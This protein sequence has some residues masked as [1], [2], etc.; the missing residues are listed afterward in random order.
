M[1][2][3]RKIFSLF[4]ILALP[5]FLLSIT[6]P[7]LNTIKENIQGNLFT[8]LGRQWDKQNVKRIHCAL[9]QNDDWSCGL[10]AF[11]HI[12]AFE[13]ALKN[14]KHFEATLAKNLQ[15]ARLLHRLY[16]NLMKAR[17][18][19]Q[20]CPCNTG[21][22]RNL[23]GQGLCD[24][25]LCKLAKQHNVLNK[26]AILDTD[27]KRTKY[28]NYHSRNYHL[29]TPQESPQQRIKRLAQQVKKGARALYS[30]S[31]LNFSKSHSHWVLYALVRLPNKPAKLYYVDSVNH[32]SFDQHRK[33]YAHFLLPYLKQVNKK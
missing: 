33:H 20:S 32:T 22:S 9:T 14:P 26:L 15:N 16:T 10:R 1:I 5:S 25:E 18:H 7:A 6:Q 4:C 12:L 13:N 17:T 28:W 8:S 29:P 2:K 30:I 31:C 3:N 21:G 24:V 23:I 27:K 11:F 19:H